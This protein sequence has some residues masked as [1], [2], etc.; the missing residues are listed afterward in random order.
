V[1]FNWAVKER[2]V[3]ENPCREIKHGPV[4]TRE[5]ILERG[6]DYTAM[7]KTL[8]RMEAEQRI[9][10]PVADAIRLIALTGCRRGEAATLRWSHV[11][12]KQ[13]RLVIPMTAH[14]TG[15]KTGKPRI[16]GLPSAA[17]AI[18]ARQPEGGPDDFVFAP[19]RGEGGAVD[20]T[21]VWVKVRAEAK[22]PAIGLH[23]L[24]HSLASH[25]AMNGAQASEIMTQLGHR[26]LST[27]QRYIHWAEDARQALAEKA[28]SVVLDA[29]AASQGRSK[30]KV[31]KLSRAR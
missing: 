16:I 5:T 19:A 22:L 7:F 10:Q 20:L 11:D 31:M 3:T 6:S 24:R 12:F 21:H 18:I 15:R 9:R 29:M 26:Q 30:G 2:L 1:I 28:A 8:D 17:Q 14:K 23:G 4:G 27:S 25:M 13:G